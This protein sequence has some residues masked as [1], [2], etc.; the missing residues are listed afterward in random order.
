MSLKSSFNNTNFISLLNV[1]WHTED[2]YPLLDQMT[3][4]I[5]FTI[6]IRAQKRRVGNEV[7]FGGSMPSSSS[8]FSESNSNLGSKLTCVMHLRGL[9]YMSPYKRFVWH[10]DVYLCGLDILP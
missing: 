5:N 7:K 10:L 3:F 2:L 9:C 1:D 8:V 4:V 6:T